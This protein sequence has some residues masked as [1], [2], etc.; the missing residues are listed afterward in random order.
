M[1]MHVYS[2]QHGRAAWICS[3]VM[4]RGHASWAYSMDMHQGHEAWRHGA[5]KC[6]LDMQA[7]PWMKAGF[8]FPDGVWFLLLLSG[9]GRGNLH[10]RSWLH[11]VLWCS[12]HQ[13]MAPHCPCRDRDIQQ[14]SA[15]RLLCNASARWHGNRYSKQL[16]N[17]Y[18]RSEATLAQPTMVNGACSDV[19]PAQVVGW[20]RVHLEPR[21]P[22]YNR[23]HNLLCDDGYC[24]GLQSLA[25]QGFLENVS[26]SSPGDC[27]IIHQC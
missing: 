16:R 10:C 2:M 20:I 23:S 1:S 3:M 12:N 22:H 27:L 7:C 5:W 8:H 9:Q 18:C 24:H 6:I 26:L 4:Q 13:A 17:S 19:D 21:C 14:P 11:R 15:V 25:H